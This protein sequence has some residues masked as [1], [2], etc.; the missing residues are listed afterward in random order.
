ML[1]IS[2]EVSPGACTLSVSAMARAGSLCEHTDNE[3]S[4]EDPYPALR[5]DDGASVVDPFS[6]LCILIGYLFFSCHVIV[7]SHINFVYK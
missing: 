3:A 7:F 1:I 4:M 2:L 6:V 5:V